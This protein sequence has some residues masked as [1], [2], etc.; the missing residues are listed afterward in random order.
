MKL[1]F[2]RDQMGPPVD[3]TARLTLYAAIEAIRA[4][5][6]EKL[7]SVLADRE[8]VVVALVRA[9]FPPTPPRYQ[10]LRFRKA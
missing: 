5:T 9:N 6:E 7:A 4:D 10:A 8:D 3:E 1:Q 2:V